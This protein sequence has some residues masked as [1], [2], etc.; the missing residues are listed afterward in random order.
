MPA[1]LPKD[2][3]PRKCNFGLLLKLMVIRMLLSIEI[4]VV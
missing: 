1:V 3:P 4:L 2:L